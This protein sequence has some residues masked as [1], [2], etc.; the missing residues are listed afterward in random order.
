MSPG[1]KMFLLSTD[2]RLMC[3]GGHYDPDLEKQNKLLTKG[4]LHGYFC[5]DFLRNFCLLG[6]TDYFPLPNETKAPKGFKQSSLP[7][8]TTS[9]CSCAGTPQGSR[10]DQRIRRS[11]VG[12]WSWAAKVGLLSLRGVCSS[13]AVQRTLSL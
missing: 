10:R 6:P 8:P 13:T 7:P 9:R 4:S 2:V 3:S 1:E 5:V 12:R 11:R